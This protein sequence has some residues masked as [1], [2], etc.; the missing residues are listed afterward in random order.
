MNET[1]ANGP[2]R[3]GLAALDRGL[4]VFLQILVAAMALCI[5]A[6]IVL[7]A[8]VQPL[9]GGWLRALDDGAG[10]EP[11]ALE[12]ALR[13]AMLVVAR[14]SAPVNTLS[15]TLLVWIGILGGSL[16]LRER[17]HP[18]VDALVRL[19]PPQV[20]L[21]LAR[22]ASALVVLFSLAVL[23]A[24]GWMVTARA[25][26]LGSKMPGIEA[27]NQGWFYLVLILAGLCN[28]VYGVE[29]F[30]HPPRAGDRSENP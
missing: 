18:G 30:M 4:T 13:G 3:R 15:Q 16:A 10:G 9:A 27:L 28:A 17:A 19:Y 20:Q 14:A 1:G 5:T 24:G 11:S 7:N 12:T 2:V 6:E 23:A 22:A 29:Q 25:F 21:W 26:E 8:L